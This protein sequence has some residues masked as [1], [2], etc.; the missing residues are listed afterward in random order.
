MFVQFGVVLNDEQCQSLLAGVDDSDR[1]YAVTSLTPVLHCV[2]YTRHDSIVSMILTFQVESK[3][4]RDCLD[5]PSSGVYKI[6]PYRAPTGIYA[7]CDMDTDGG[8]W[9][10]C[11]SDI[12][13]HHME[14]LC[15]C[16]YG[17]RLSNRPFCRYTGIEIE[18]GVTS[19]MEYWFVAW[20]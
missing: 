8:G 19:I 12:L 13:V 1:T 6:H 20:I 7:Y 9:T 3:K 2:T 17:R 14:P 5:A 10:V 18:A 4:I 16:V 15:T 11:H